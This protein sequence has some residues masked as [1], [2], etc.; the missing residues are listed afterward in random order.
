MGD[1][2]VEQVVMEHRDRLMRFGAEPPGAALAARVG[3]LPV[4]DESE[5]KA[6]L[7]QDMI[8]MLTSFCARLPDRWSARHRAL[9]ALAACAAEEPA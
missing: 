7:V 2:T 9:R 1:S 6:D 3:K 8:S 4:V 5:R